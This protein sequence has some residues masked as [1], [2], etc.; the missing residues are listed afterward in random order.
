MRSTTAGM[1]LAL[2]LAVSTAFAGPVVV[3]QVAPLSGL[4]A[5]QGK[6]YG[7]GMKLALAA[8][9]GPNTFTL[10][11][12][13]DAG[14]PENTIKLTQQMLAEDKPLVLGGYFGI[15]NI[16][17][18]ARSG[19][20]TKEGIALVGYRAAQVRPETQNLY[21]VRAGL[22][23]EM[24]KVA[25]HLGTIGIT[26]LALVYEQGPGGV[27][28]MA[29]ASEAAQRAKAQIIG[30][31][32]YP[33]GTTNVQQAVQAMQKAQPQA[34]ML[35]GPG[36]GAAAFIEQYRGAGGGAQ[37]FANST[38]D[39]EQLAAKLNDQQM[40][41]VSIVQVVPSPFKMSTRIAKEFSDAVAKAGKTEVPPSYAMLEGYI[42]G[43]VI[44]EAVNRQGKNPTR[45]G[46]L[47]A[48]DGM[49]FYE[50]GGYSVSYRPDIH[51]GSRFVELTILG[52]KGKVRQ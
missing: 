14:S 18:L 46:T 2:G 42:A 48:L 16:D 15:R 12:K 49:H 34:I 25:E 1:V 19:L 22:R 28:L 24:F 41:G 4:D 31:A 51:A 52:G 35:I 36:A 43:K 20:L 26:K 45:E 3:G 5:N 32:G 27:A 17:D 8:A 30:M 11:Q 40:M 21:N 29:S 50:M 44:T 47:K 23:E 33:A 38:I 10:V 6:A 9:K 7:I 39:M 13:D 37:L